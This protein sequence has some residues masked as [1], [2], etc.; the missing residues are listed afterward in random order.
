MPYD[1]DVIVVG[2][3]AGGATFAYACARAGKSVLLI[4]RGRQYVPEVDGAGERAMLIDKK[5]YD[6][7][8][9]EVNG[10]AKRLYMGGVLGGGTA[11]YGAALLRPSIE[12]FHPGRAYGK[13]IPRAIWDWPI[14]YDALEPY[15]TEAER[16][17]GVSGCGD[18]DFGPLQKPRHGFPTT[19]M[20]LHPINQKLIAANRADGLRPFQLAAGDRLRPLPPLL[21]LRR[22][23]LSQR[24]PPFL[25][26]ARGAGRCR[27]GCLCAC[28]PTS[29]W[30]ASSWKG[31]ATSP[32][33]DFWTARHGQRS[34][35]PRS[36]LRAGRGGRRRP[37]FCC[38]PASMGHWS[39]AT[40]WRICRP[41]SSASFRRR[42]GAETTFVKQVGF[43]DY[44]FGSKT[45]AH[46]LGLVQSLPVPGPLL[47]AKTAPLVPS[48]VGCCNSCG[49]GCSPSWGSSR[50]CRIPPTASS[51]GPD[52]QPRLR[53][54]SAPTTSNAAT[55][56]AA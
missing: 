35:L 3:G 33:F 46:K 31:T 47:A 23:H 13:R 27:A 19:P 26:S 18:E 30:R 12:D 4:E 11:L 38:G 21:R 50:I 5:P 20:S 1:C 15:Y 16:L 22:L 40:T 48:R 34:S 8:T 2:S 55:N 49:D 45:F 56:W 54:S 10:S 9:V 52:G 37:R 36:A 42:T 43:A 39:A 41:S 24:C 29:R 28:A 44:Y 32:A 6:D 51:W 7:R 25:R 53:I 14:G 17:Y